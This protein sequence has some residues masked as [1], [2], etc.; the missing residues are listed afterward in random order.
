MPDSG[1]YVP[2]KYVDEAPDIQATISQKKRKA[3]L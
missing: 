2:S 1:L 3:A